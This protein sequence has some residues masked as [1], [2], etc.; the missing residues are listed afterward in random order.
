LEPPGQ[1]RDVIKSRGN[2]ANDVGRRWG[3]GDQFGRHGADVSGYRGRQR[4]GGDDGVV[5][6]RCRGLGS[7]CKGG[8]RAGGRGWE[9][10]GRGGG[11]DEGGRGGGEDEGGVCAHGGV[12]A[13]GRGGGEDEVGGCGQGR[14]ECEWGRGGQLQQLPAPWAAHFGVRLLKGVGRHV[15]HDG[16]DEDGGEGPKGRHPSSKVVNITWEENAAVFRD[17]K[18][19]EK[20]RRNVDPTTW[21]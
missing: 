2:G 3:L 19:F 18:R 13:L 6:G 10:Y 21:S 1:S 11:E 8:N 17:L 9:G 20:H 14:G 4:G 12:R 16:K 7:C 5:W 15:G